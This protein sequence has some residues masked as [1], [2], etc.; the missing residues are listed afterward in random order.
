MDMGPPTG[1]YTMFNAGEEGVGGTVPLDSSQG[2]PSHWVSYIT[3]NDV[4][5]TC[6][7]TKELDGQV[8]QDPFDIPNVGRMAVVQDPAGAVFSPFKDKDPNWK[9][10]TPRAGTFAWHEMMSTDIEK[11]KPFYT[12]IIGWELGS[13]DMGEAGT[14]WLFR[15]NGQDVAGGMQMPPDSPPH[16]NWLPYV[17]VTDI[18]GTVET[19]KKLGG[20]VIVP[21]QKV[22]DPVNV[23]FA[24]LASPDG[25]SF[26]ILEM[27]S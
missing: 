25:A 17:G 21:P 16:S 4:D 27:P 2:I 13:M 3:V 8:I 11:A 24:I 23:H 5:Q 7:R 18:P 26:G 9:P 19:C 15:K 6:D 1:I 12:D 20:A 22:D 10:P 14:Y